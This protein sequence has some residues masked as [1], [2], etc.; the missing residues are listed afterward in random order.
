MFILYVFHTNG[1]LTGRNP[2]N[3]REFPG[4]F[5]R[6]IQ[7]IKLVV[8]ELMEMGFLSDNSDH[9]IFRITEE[10]HTIIPR[11]LMAGIGI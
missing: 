9:T 8:D 7:E 1:H 10:G 3:E 5:G 4:L 2:I 11:K 6:P